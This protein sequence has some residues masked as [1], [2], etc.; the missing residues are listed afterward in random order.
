MTTPPPP[1]TLIPGP[2]VDQTPTA[3][4]LAF[5]LVHA[6]EDLWEA[7]TLEEESQMYEDARRAASRVLA[8]CPLE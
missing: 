6:A 4:R 3:A 7:A 8:V 1:P 5:I 2:L